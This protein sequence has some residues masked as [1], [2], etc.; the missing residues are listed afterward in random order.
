VIL[1]PTGTISGESIVYRSVPPVPL[2]ARLPGLC[3]FFCIIAAERSKPSINNI[4][5]IPIEPAVLVVNKIVWIAIEPADK[6]ILGVRI[7]LE[8]REINSAL[9]LID[10]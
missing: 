10:S 3:H 2:K 9:Y 8:I 4:S 1:F 7:S 6:M 5:M